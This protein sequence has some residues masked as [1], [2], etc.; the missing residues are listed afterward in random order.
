MPFF[1]VLFLMIGENTSYNLNIYDL[2]SF[3]VFF[4]FDEFQCLF[5]SLGIMVFQIK[6]IHIF[7]IFTSGQRGLQFTLM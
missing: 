5:F 6:I 7:F 3:S 1:P 2:K 4:F